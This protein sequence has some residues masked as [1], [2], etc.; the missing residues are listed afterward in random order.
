[1]QRRQ[2]LTLCGAT[3]LLALFGAGALLLRAAPGPA[4]AT[5][6]VGDNPDCLGGCM[7]VDAS[8]RQAFVSNANGI[9]SVI[10]TASG[11]LVHTINVSSGGINQPYEIAVDPHVGHA[12]VSSLAGGPISI[13]DTHRAALLGSLPLT[14]P[15]AL[16]LD[17]MTGRVF[18]SSYTD[19]KVY[20]LDT[21][22][23]RVLRAIDVPSPKDS[24]VDERRGHVFVGTPND[25]L[26]ML[27]AHSG[28]ALRTIPLNP[29]PGIYPNT[30]ALDEHL[31][32]L[33]VTDRETYTV[34]IV[35]TRS[36]SIMKTVHVGPSGTNSTFL[37]VVADAR[38]GHVF[39]GDETTKTVWML[40]A[41]RGVVLRTV[42]LHH[43]VEFLAV[44]NRTGEILVSTLG[45][46]D[47]SGLPTGDG[48]VWVLDGHSGAV[49]RTIPVGVA[50]VD[51]VVDENRQR[52][53]VL[54]TN[55]DPGTNATPM[56]TRPREGVTPQVL[57]RI[58]QALP[59][60]PFQ[61]P[62]PPA[63]T[64]HGSVTTL[65]LTGV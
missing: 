26:H 59:W 1:M 29:K 49:R 55:A 11:R 30:L 47:R 22:T 58:K 34:F 19:S 44:V 2:W 38:T 25:G 24:V 4:I 21:H 9:V 61:A 56:Q 64:T 18:V 12:F 40:D 13:L 62:K 36:G 28:A 37:G 63:L 52:A 5:V 57:R 15:T 3:L 32:R 39:V 23:T 16:S 35:D 54:D 33:F 41:R 53:L 6:T 14:A 48:A 60:L 17:T 20:M 8:A 45:Q 27:D 46:T 31:G 7:A 42:P 50:P 51:I 43:P 10:D 65:D